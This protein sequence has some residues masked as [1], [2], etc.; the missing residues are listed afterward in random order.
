MGKETKFILTEP[1]QIS[2]FEEQDDSILREYKR[3]D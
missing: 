2:L 3:E 1:K